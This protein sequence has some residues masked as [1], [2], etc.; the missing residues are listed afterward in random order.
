MVKTEFHEVCQS[1]EI[2]A[3]IETEDGSL[4]VLVEGENYEGLDDL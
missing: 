3:L 1:G 4:V 2:V